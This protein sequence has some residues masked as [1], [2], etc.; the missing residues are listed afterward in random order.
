[1]APIH[2]LAEISV[3]PYTQSPI[4]TAR[5]DRAQMD[6]FHGRLV[7]SNSLEEQVI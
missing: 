5:P 4:V 7:K 2:P 3:S 1:M 6:F